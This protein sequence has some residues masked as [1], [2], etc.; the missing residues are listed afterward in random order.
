MTRQQA[1]Q[2]M[3]LKISILSLSLVVFGLVA[4]YI[5]LLSATVVHV[6]MTQEIKRE[7]AT[8]QSTNS[9]LER[10]YINRQHAITSE[11]AMQNGFTVTTDKIFIARQPNILVLSADVVRR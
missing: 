4:S 1:K 6:V 5:Y 2:K 8:V 11:I 10:E 9:E 7:M 3:H